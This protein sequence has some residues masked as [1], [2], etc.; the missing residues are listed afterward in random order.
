MSLGASRVRVVVEVEVPEGD[1]E[2]VYREEFRRELAK[3]TLNIL[4]DRGTEP[5]REAVEEILREK[6]REEGKRSP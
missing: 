3:R 1:E 6:K 5:A 4:L 2:G